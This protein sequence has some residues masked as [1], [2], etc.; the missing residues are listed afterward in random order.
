MTERLEYLMYKSG[1][2]A[3]GSWDEMDSYDQ[4]AILKFAELIVADSIEALEQR[5]KTFKGS[6][7][8]Y[9]RGFKSGLDAATRTVKVHFGV[10]K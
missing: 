10:D 7:N 4:E 2:T 9:A 6:G 1:L 3:S 5:Y 8:E